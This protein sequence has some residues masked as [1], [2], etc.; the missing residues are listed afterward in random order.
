[1]FVRDV[2]GGWGGFH[3]VGDHFYVIVA[4]MP[5]NNLRL[6]QLVGHMN[7]IRE[8]AITKTYHT[9]HGVVLGKETTVSS[10]PGSLNKMI[11]YIVV[12]FPSTLKV[13]EKKTVKY[14]TYFEK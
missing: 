7:A 13:Q 12:F 3:N 8:V 6:T 11:L 9:L 2:P 4:G 14:I 1:V 10:P 5:L